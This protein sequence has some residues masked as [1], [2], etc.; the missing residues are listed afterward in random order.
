MNTNLFDRFISSILCEQP[1]DPELFPAEDVARIR[2]IM[3]YDPLNPE[4]TS[5]EA[6]EKLERAFY[7]VSRKY[8]FFSSLKNQAINII[9]KPGD[10]PI[11]TINTAAVDKKGNFLYNPDFVMKLTLPEVAGLVMHELLHIGNEDLYRVEEILGKEG[12]PVDWM[13]WNI[14]ADL[15]NNYWIAADIVNDQSSDIKL[16]PGGLHPDEDGVVR[17]VISD[18]HQKK[19][20]IPEDQWIDLNDKSTEEVYWALKKLDDDLIREIDDERLDIHFAK[21][22]ASEIIEVFDLEDGDPPPPPPPP[23]PGGNPKF[24]DLTGAVVQDKVTGAWAVVVKD[25]QH[26]NTEIVHISEDEAKQL[27]VAMSGGI[28]DLI[29][30]SSGQKPIRRVEQH[31][32]RLVV[33]RAKSEDPNA[34]TNS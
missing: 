26:S 17:K 30:K 25:D 13:R 16:P 28:G 6:Y 23:P 1:E 24:E 31:A 20:D 2:R 9:P 32:K 5:E 29:R 12:N 22:S 21:L 3:D 4:F 14:A 19:I 11:P 8:M 18:L 10:P 27:V 15:V 34:Q 33:H 7:L